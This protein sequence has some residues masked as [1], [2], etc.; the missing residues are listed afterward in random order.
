[1]RTITEKLKVVSEQIDK[2]RFSDMSNYELSELIDLYASIC[3]TQGQC[4]VVTASGQIAI[5]ANLEYLSS[6]CT[7]WGRRDELGLL[8]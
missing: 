1:M 8:D 7:E 5:D 4:A 2:E 6:L 3:E